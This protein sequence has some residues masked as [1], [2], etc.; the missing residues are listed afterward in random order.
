MPPFAQYLFTGHV[1]EKFAND[2]GH[3]DLGMG[4]LSRLA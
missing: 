2:L 4:L 3:L 1:S